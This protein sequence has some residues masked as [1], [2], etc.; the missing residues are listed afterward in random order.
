MG[1]PFA[2]THLR[3][4]QGNGCYL[5][6]FKQADTITKQEWDQVDVDFVEQSS[7]E[8]LLR[9]RRGSYHDRFAACDHSR[10]FKSAFNAVGYEGHRPFLLD[11]FWWRSMGHDDNRGTDGM[12]ASPAMCE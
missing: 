11:P 2:D 9:N 8:A 4:F 6:M 3:V 1:D 10:L 5:E 7:V 12:V